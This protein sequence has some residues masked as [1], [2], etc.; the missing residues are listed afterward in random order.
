MSKFS[1]L[2]QSTFFFPAYFEIIKLYIKLVTNSRSA[3]KT[4]KK[5]KKKKKQFFI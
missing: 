2:F 1:M 3:C 5:K 4:H